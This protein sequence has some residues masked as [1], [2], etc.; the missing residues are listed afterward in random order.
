MPSENFDQAILDKSLE[1]IQNPHYGYHFLLGDMVSEFRVVQD[2]PREPDRVYYAII[3]LA[4]NCTSS[5]LVGMRY[6]HER[7]GPVG[8]PE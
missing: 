4:E 1:N 3:F 5:P 6:N 8:M 7:P 2:T